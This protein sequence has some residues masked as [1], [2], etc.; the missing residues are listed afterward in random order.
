MIIDNHTFIDL[1]THLEGASK[2]IL[3]VTRG[4]VTLCENAN[5][6][7]SEEV[8]GLIESLIVVN[9]TLTALEQTLR[10]LLEANQEEDTT[11]H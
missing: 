8:I 1:V 5:E 9:T 10:A 6:E 11:Q 3:D 2:G 7:A 4:C